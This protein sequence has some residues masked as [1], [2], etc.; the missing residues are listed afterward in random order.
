MNL[1]YINLNITRKV[2]NQP[3]VIE[4]IDFA[5]PADTPEEALEKSA[6]YG[7]NGVMQARVEVLG[8]DW[9]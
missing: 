7:S 6:E 4:D 8:K 3:D 9:H 5:I 1:Y 2:K